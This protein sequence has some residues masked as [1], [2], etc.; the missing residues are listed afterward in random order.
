MPVAASFL[1]NE[2]RRF[3]AD[4]ADPHAGG[5]ANSVWDLEHCGHV[6]RAISAADSQLLG[7]ATP[8]LITNDRRIRLA[9]RDV[10][11]EDLILD[12]TA[13]EAAISADAFA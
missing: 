10:H 9:A 12:R 1:R 8:L 2:L 3:T 13:Y 6:S 4:A 5:N 11:H 7:N